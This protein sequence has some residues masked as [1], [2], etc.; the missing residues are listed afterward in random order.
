MKKTSLIPIL[1]AAG[2]MAAGAAVRAQTFDS[3]QQA[4]EASTMTH[5]VPNALTTN[6]PFPDGTPVYATV[7]PAYSYGYGYVAPAVVAAAPVYGYIDA[8]PPH[9]YDYGRAN[10]TSDVPT[11]AGEASTYTGGV[12]NMLTSNA[13]R[14]GAPY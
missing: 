7:V 4:G 6:S 14:Y 8:V 1:C 2:L 11:R 13:A 5:G 12:P 3:P 10:L 9:A